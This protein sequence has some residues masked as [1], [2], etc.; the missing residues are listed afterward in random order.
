GGAAQER[1]RRPQRV[2]LR[3]QPDAPGAPGD[4][5]GISAPRGP[6]A[7][8]SVRTRAQNAALVPGLLEEYAAAT[9]DPVRGNT[10]ALPG[11]HPIRSNPDSAQLVS[12][13]AMA[14][15]KRLGSAMVLRA[16]HTSLGWLAVKQGVP[17]STPD[18]WH[19]RSSFA[20]A[21]ARPKE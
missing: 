1:Q 19:K 9:S 4:E 16:A 6:M 15:A 14:L 5:G 18:R 3:R 11:Y 8:Q 13:Q 20:S 12:E 17:R 21:K 2:H 7:D 10:L